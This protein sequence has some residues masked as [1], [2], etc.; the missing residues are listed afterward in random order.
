MGISDDQSRNG[1]FTVAIN[2]QVKNLKRYSKVK[3]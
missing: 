1:I 2:R 3:N